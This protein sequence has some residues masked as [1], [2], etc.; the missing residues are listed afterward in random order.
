MHRPVS[1]TATAK[2]YT[3][4]RNEP[5]KR[6]RNLRCLKAAI[7]KIHMT[8]LERHGSEQVPEHGAEIGAQGVVEEVKLPDHEVLQ[9]DAQA[10]FVAQGV[11]LRRHFARKPGEQWVWILARP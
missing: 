11:R 4:K 9:I 7:N 8:Y 1:T 3:A 2:A 10:L 5:H 6:S